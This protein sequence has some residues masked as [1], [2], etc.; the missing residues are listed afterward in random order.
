VKESG[1]RLIN[2]TNKE[3]EEQNEL[4]K[5]QLT[6]EERLRTIKAQTN[7]IES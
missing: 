3:L 7:N 6:M 1:D 4:R 5:L 2:N